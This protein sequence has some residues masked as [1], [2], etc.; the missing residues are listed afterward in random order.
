MSKIKLTKEEKKDA[1]AGQIIVRFA[2][3]P[4]YKYIK[5]P[6]SHCKGVGYN[7]HLN[8]AWI[9]K[10]REIKK[11]SLRTMAKSLG[12]SAA[13]LSDVELGR[14]AGNKEIENYFK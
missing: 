8:G 13:Y 6:C 5:K 1:A 4:I 3:A 14:R 7:I 2:D 10:T 9:R 11:I 12:I